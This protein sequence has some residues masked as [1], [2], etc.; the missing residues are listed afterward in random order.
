DELVDRSV[1]VDMAER[2][3]ADDDLLLGNVE[4]RADNLVE[5][6]EGGLRASVQ[7]VAARG[8]HQA[9]Q[10]NTEIEPASDFEVLV[11]GKDHADRRA[12][13]LVVAHPRALCALEIAL[14]N[15]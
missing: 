14:G 6:C 2:H 1:R 11:E 13:E 4:Q 5:V 9:A 8:D 15:T 10:I 3:A 12:K 7:P